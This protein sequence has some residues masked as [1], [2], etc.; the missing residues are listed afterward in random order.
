MIG[1]ATPE[2]TAQ[3][4]HEPILLADE[5]QEYHR[6]ALRHLRWPVGGNG[7]GASGDEE[8]TAGLRTLGITSCCRG[9]G[10]STVA[11][12]LAATAA[13]M[14]E[15]RVLLVDANLANPSVHEIFD[16]DL[17]PGLAESL[18]NPKMLETAVQPTDSRNLFVLS[19]GEP[20]GDLPKAFDTAAIS[21]VTEALRLQ[22]KLV[23]FDMPPAGQQ[24]TALRL[25]SL[26]D[27]VLMVVEAERVRFEVARR[28]TQLLGRAGAQVLGAVLNKRRRYVPTWLTDSL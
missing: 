22:Y 19:A 5:I 12:Q 21:Q 24:S 10:V 14:N 6:T 25:G 4:G 20:N 13:E 7:N 15:G 26:F 23:V 27:G 16:V 11:A 2:A 1:Q 17:S 3:T 8:T 9:E 18:L 28:T